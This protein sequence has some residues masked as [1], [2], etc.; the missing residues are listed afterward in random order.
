MILKVN[1]KYSTFSK[2]NLT[3]KQ[4][5]TD[6]EMNIVANA[7]NLPLN[8]KD[9]ESDRTA[10]IQLNPLEEKMNKYKDN[11]PDPIQQTDEKHLKLDL[12]EN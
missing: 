4:Q 8:T 1:I 6:Q 9:E 5:N 10:D 2:V 3:G 7:L 11:E 12:E